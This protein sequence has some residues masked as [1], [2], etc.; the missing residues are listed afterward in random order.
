VVV[1]WLLGTAI[2]VALA[3]VYSEV[4]GVETRERHRVRHREVE[5]A[6]PHRVLRILGGP[7]LRRPGPRA[8]VHGAAVALVGVALIAL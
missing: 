2:A 7:V 3:E 6:G 8:L 1:G 5:W 4:I